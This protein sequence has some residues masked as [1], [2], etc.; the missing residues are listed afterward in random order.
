[1]R[2]GSCKC[3]PCFLSDPQPCPWKEF[4]TGDGIISDGVEHTIQNVGELGRQGMRETD[5]VILEMMTREPC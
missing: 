3:F 4:R 2:S 1:M 5:H